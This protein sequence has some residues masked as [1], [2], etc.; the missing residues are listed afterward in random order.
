MEGKRSVS[1]VVG[2]FFCNDQGQFDS[3][4]WPFFKVGLLNAKSWKNEEIMILNTY[5][6]K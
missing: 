2:F 4:P 3:Y 6:E 5:K 1:C